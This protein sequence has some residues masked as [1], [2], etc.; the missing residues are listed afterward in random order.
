LTL[1]VDKS[2]PDDRL[3]AGQ[4]VADLDRIGLTV[5]V[6]VV[7]AREFADQLRKGSADLALDHVVAP[8][9]R[10]SA[11]AA[12]IEALAGDIDRARACLTG[13]CSSGSLK[14]AT[15]RLGLV[16]LVRLQLRV[17]YDARIGGVYLTPSGTIDFGALYWRRR[18]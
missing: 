2:R 17:H 12:R 4:L 10:S 8:V 11:A 13:S 6:K 7:T 16:P 15:K 18:H 9:P 5:Q 3:L 14:L 1:L